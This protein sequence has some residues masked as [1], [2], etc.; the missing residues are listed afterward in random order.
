MAHIIE[1]YGTSNA[2]NGN[3]ENMD[4][5]KFHKQFKYTQ[6]GTKSKA[7]K[8]F[9][10]LKSRT[11]VQINEVNSIYFNIIVPL[12]INCLISLLW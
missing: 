6:K 2:N 3:E 11:E 4:E 9:E 12:C 8:T 7:N 1:L 10:P 5:C